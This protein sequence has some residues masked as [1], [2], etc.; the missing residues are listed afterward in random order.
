MKLVRI[1]AE[2]PRL[3]LKVLSLRLPCRLLYLGNLLQRR[4]PVCLYEVVKQPVHV[5]GI[6]CHT[7]F[8]HIFGIR[9]VSQQLCNLPPQVHYPP[10]Y[11]YVVLRIVVRTLCVACHIHLLAQAALRRVC[12]ERAE[13]RIVEREYPPLLALFL[14]S[15][16][17]CLACRVG[18]TVQ[19]FLVGYVQAV[20]L[21]LLQQVLRELQRQHACLLRKA[22]QPFLTLFVQQRTAADKSVIAVVKQPFLFGCQPAMVPVHGLYT[23]KQALVQAHVVGVLCQYGLYLL[24][25]SVHFFVC[26]RAQKVEEH[27]GHARQKVVISL[28]VILRIYYRIVES[29]LLCVVYRLVYQFVVSPYAFHEGLFKVFHAYVSERHRVVRRAVRFQERVSAL[30]FFFSIIA[31]SCMVFCQLAKLF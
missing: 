11:L 4:R 1:I 14:C 12:H 31:H 15:K 22:A 3:H 18:Q 19:L 16:G 21:V 10:A 8:Q 9:P 25:Q 29:G 24:C 26:L 28:L 17:G 6:A 5:A 7:V 13:A 2:V 30:S 27:R 23:L 20:C